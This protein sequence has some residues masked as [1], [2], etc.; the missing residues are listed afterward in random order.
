[1]EHAGWAVARFVL[2]ELPR[3]RRICVL[4]GK[5]NN[6]G[7]GFVAARH[8]AEVGCDVS[9]VILGKTAEVGGDAKV[10][11]DKLPFAPISVRQ[12]SDLARGELKEIFAQSELFLDAVV[13]TGFHPP[14]RGLAVAAR[15]LLNS[16]PKTPVVAVDLP[17]GWDADSRDQ[18]AD[19][20]FS[21]RCCRDLYR[22]QAGA[23]F[24]AAHP[25]W[26]V[27]PLGES[28]AG[29]NRR[30]AYRFAGGRH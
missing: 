3:C 22:A 7:D 4:C 29:S 8:L 13:G 17:S 1:M 19:G 26:R 12:E 11:L 9:V 27:D 25:G 30:C 6:G 10:M 5:G 14:L 15:E 24:W 2:R 18:T 16:Y 23:C 20:A 21:R 28:Q